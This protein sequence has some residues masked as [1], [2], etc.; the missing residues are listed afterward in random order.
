MRMQCY[1]LSEL[2]WVQ[3]VRLSLAFWRVR[4]V[5]ICSFLMHYFSFCLCLKPSRIILKS[6][7]LCSGKTALAATV[8]IDSGF[9]FVKFVI[10]GST[11]CY[12]WV[13]R[14]LCAW[15]INFWFS[16]G[17]L[18]LGWNYD[19]TG[20]A[21]QMCTNCEGLWPVFLLGQRFEEYEISCF[22]LTF[23]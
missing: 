1:W 21:D 10:F 9:P 14:L 5:G 18:G 15:D 20:R 8:G 17:C 3:A 4:V 16:Y 19:R 13:I 22:P 2:K 11:L 12:L 23:N 7:R 6:C